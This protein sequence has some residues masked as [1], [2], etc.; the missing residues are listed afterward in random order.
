VSDVIYILLTLVAFGLLAALV[1]LLDRR[2]T[3]DRGAE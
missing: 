1:G 2:L 3:D